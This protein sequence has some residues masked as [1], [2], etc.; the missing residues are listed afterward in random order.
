MFLYLL[1][2]LGPT[3]RT[4]FWGVP[5]NALVNPKCTRSQWLFTGGSIE[6]APFFQEDQLWWCQHCCPAHGVGGE[7]N[8]WPRMWSAQW[9]LL[10]YPDHQDRLP[11]RTGDTAG[12][13]VHCH[14]HPSCHSS[15]TRVLCIPSPE[16]SPQTF[17]FLLQGG[18]SL[19]C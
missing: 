2:C 18:S 7:A 10:S 5:T 9:P 17:T 19:G 4:H 8:G 16:C 15:A 6:R 14:P 12:H 1:R 3:F 13:S 11:G